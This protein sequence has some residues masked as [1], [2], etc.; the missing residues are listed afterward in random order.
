[1]S[2]TRQA[3]EALAQEIRRVDGNHSLGAAELAEALMPFISSL[4][5]SE[6]DA[7]EAKG[8][9]D[10]VRAALSA[11]PEQADRAGVGEAFENWWAVTGKFI[12][13]DSDDV[14]W[15]DKRK[16]L[17]EEAF[18]AALRSTARGEGET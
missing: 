15:Y 14:H 9:P 7:P 11:L 10:V 8:L 4:H 16:G 6:M 18:C 13:P 3:I 2:A 17:A 1:M 5:S 12:D